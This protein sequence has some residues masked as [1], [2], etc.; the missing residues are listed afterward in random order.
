MLAT[1]HLFHVLT[2]PVS[3]WGGEGEELV[4]SGPGLE[5][6]RRY[7]QSEDTGGMPI[8]AVVSCYDLTV[9]VEPYSTYC[10]ALDDNGAIAEFPFAGWGVYRH[11]RTVTW[12]GENPEQGATFPKGGGVCSATTATAVA[13]QY[14]ARSEW[15]SDAL[16][17]GVETVGAPTVG[18]SSVLMQ[19]GQTGRTTTT[20]WDASILASPNPE[21]SYW[22]PKLY[23]T[24]TVTDL[25]P[26]GCPFSPCSVT[27]TA[28]F[29]QSTGRLNSS[30]VSGTGASRTVAFS[31]SNGDPTTE[32]ISGTG[33]SGTFVTTRSF[34]NGQVTSSQ[35]TGIG[36]L[37]FDVTRDSAL[38]LVTASRD[39]NNQET[40]YTW[41]N[42]ARL[43]AVDP[44][45]TL[46]H[47]TT[48]CYGPW[49]PASGQGT[50]TGAW[51]LVRR[52]SNT[53]CDLSTIGAPAAGSE[54]VEGY[55]YDGS[56]RLSREI[57]L[58]PNTLTGSGTSNYLAVRT[59]ERNGIG[60]VTAVSEWVP[61]GT[62]SN[63]STCFTATTSDTYKTRFS[64]FDV[65]GR[66]GKVILPDGT[67]ITK[68]YDDWQTN[69]F[70]GN[71]LSSTDT[72]EDTWTK[73][74]TGADNRSYEFVR[75]DIFGRPII[76]S[77]PI[78]LAVNDSPTAGPLT[79]YRHDIHDQV[80]EVKQERTPSGGTAYTQ[81]RFFSRNALGFLTSETQPES[82][83]TTYALFTALGYPQTKTRGSL[84]DPKTTSTTYDAL[85]RVVTVSAASA[86]VVNTYDESLDED[87]LPRGSSKGKL[88][89][90]TNSNNYPSSGAG[91]DFYPRGTISDSYTYT[92][93]GGRLSQKKTTLSNGSASPVARWTYDRHGL[94]ETEDHP[95]VPGTPGFLVRTTY[96]AGL[97]R[98]VTAAG[99]TVASSVTYNPSGGLASYTSG[100]GVV[101]TIVPD[102]S[103][104]PRPKRIFTSEVSPPSSNFDT[105]DFT[106]DGAGN[107]TSMKRTEED[108]D[109]FTY[110]A[111]SRLLSAKYPAVSSTAQTYS[112]DGW[113]NLTRKAGTTIPVNKETNRLTNATYSP[114][115]NL[116]GLGAETYR[117]DGLDRQVR[118][119]A[120]GSRFN[121][122]FD[123]SNERIV[124]SIPPSQVVYVLRRDMAR[125]ILQAMG[126]T[127]KATCA[128]TFTDVPCS[129][130]DR[131]WIEKFYDRGITLGCG[132]GRFCPNGTM[133][134]FEMAVFLARALTLPGS[135]PAS[136]T[137]PTGETYSCAPE[138]NTSLFTDVPASDGRCPHVHYLL[139]QG[140]TQGCEAPPNRRFCPMVSTSHYE[141]Q[142]F[143]SRAWAGSSYIPSGAKYTFRGA[144]GSIRTEYE[145]SAVA[146]DYVYLGARLV[147]TKEGTVWKYHATDHLGSVRLTTGSSRTVLETRK[148]W[149]WGE[150]AD[151]SGPSV[152]AFA[153]MER[154]L[155]V[156]EPFRPRYYVHA[157]NLETGFG[158]FLSPDMLS[159]TVEDPL[160]W[161]RY[162]YARNNPLKYVDPDG[163]DFRD[164]TDG[165]ANA[166]W[167]NQIVG[168]ERRDSSNRDFRFGQAFGDAISVI[169][170]AIQTIGGGTVAVGGGA[171]EAL[172]LGGST[173]VSVPMVAGGAAVAIPGAKAAVSGL[174]N[175]MK[176][177]GSESAGEPAKEGTPSTARGS[178]D[179][180]RGRNAMV[181]K[182]TGEVW[183]KEH[184]RHGGE[185]YSVYKDMKAFEQK[186]RYRKVWADG[187]PGREL[188]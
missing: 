3:G 131:G 112:Y 2:E 43:R 114:H 13:C 184:S 127:P 33:L 166:F 12:Y 24:R 52:G 148:Y 100:N 151:T 5:V 72:R 132:G 121:Y 160:S 147:G 152:L 71:K 74:V 40:T 19:A 66:P 116:T 73:N 11:S 22:H 86:Y 90:S 94:V 175:L 42:L 50:A 146:R 133:T 126:E 167:S 120:P 153:G 177:S 29:D 77:E 56:G 28:N 118:H 68:R 85:G 134:R 143:A 53:S 106:Y 6:E 141:M 108:E 23:T 181:H 27:T 164:F 172:T 87:G 182:K 60:L 99:Q 26:G 76:A 67:Q 82:G 185:N 17:F 57:R 109:T 83:L 145:D 154:D 61:C 47:P 80:A 135:V 163:K 30:T 144:G 10:G 25:F 183:V 138:G 97:P 119:E 49:T 15:N 129:D 21:L 69:F 31:Y 171:L 162:A 168:P 115:G 84:S 89:T 96:W 179:S 125:I 173:P 63:P 62:G 92:G 107:I 32:T 188:K 165:V 117:Y 180:V 81:T 75:K 48:I 4:T 34:L 157:R 136:G 158:R 155:E 186:H 150:E 95:R 104:M 124:K 35:R 54:T 70:S 91:P 123:A 139:K 187:T 1:R 137:V 178:F 98:T 36:W 46:E 78:A 44:P 51:A 88:T 41:D 14:V 79:Y 128:G 142:L 45:G 7:Y 156:G 20:A 110:D 65:L 55:V 161:N 159:G 130:P 170:G 102:D 113:S 169:G 37:Q 16:E 111:A 93:I 101:T 105:G 149:P 176:A 64:E 58:L 59:T 103:R 18:P 39:P 174:V 122:L 38:G 9:G 140:V 8:R